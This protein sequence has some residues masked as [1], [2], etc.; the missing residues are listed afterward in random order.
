MI[1]EYKRTYR[2]LVEPSL[3]GTPTG[4]SPSPINMNTHPVAKR[5]SVQNSDDTEVNTGRY[6]VP[7][8]YAGHASI[9]DGYTGYHIDDSAVQA[10]KSVK[11]RP[12]NVIIC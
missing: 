3:P 8:G 10:I 4:R 5:D 6:Q 9:G 12:E 1:E 7:K 11:K 2:H